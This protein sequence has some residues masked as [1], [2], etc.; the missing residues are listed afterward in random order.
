[1]IPLRKFLSLPPS[2]RLRKAHRLLR[3]WE[4]TLL[5]GDPFPEPSLMAGFLAAL[6]GCGL[7]PDAARGRDRLLGVLSGPGPASPE[8][9]LRE[10][11]SLRHRM[12]SDLGME[13]ADWDL[14]QPVGA[15]GPPRRVLPC[16]VYADLIRSP[17]NLGS[18]FRTSECFGVQEI[19]IAPGGASPE[20]P[21]ARRSAMGSID[22]VPH[23]YAE[24]E[25]LEACDGVFALE[26]GG[27]PLGDFAFPPQGICVVGSEELGVRSGLRRLAESR[28]GIVS[29]PL[30]GAKGSLNVSVAFGILMHAWSCA[31]TT[32]S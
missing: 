24:P 23:R 26:T 1:M 27:T 20:H 11:D 17:F 30:R 6:D 22:L 25:E 2:T 8:E 10:L 19:L 21:R 3:Q 7:S 28:A 4:K 16:R 29:L 13:T 32:D 15:E 18:I 9:L 5:S 14:L 31:L 12:A